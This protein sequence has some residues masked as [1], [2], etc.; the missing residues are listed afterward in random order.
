MRRLLLLGCA[1]ASLGLSAGSAA[2]QAGAA[3]AVYLDPSKPISQRVDDLIGRM[4]L[5]EKAVQM[6]NSTPAIPR[7]GVPAYDYWSEALHGVMLNARSS[8]VFPEPIGLAASFDAPQIKQMASAI[9]EEGRAYF[10]IV[11]RHG[12]HHF[13]QG[14]TFFA[15][16]INI[17]RDPRWGRGQE[18]YG[19]DPWLTGK[20]GVAFITGLQG[21]DPVHLRAGATAKHIAAYSGPEPGRYEFD[22]KVSQHDL[23]DTFLPPFRAAVVE[24]KVQSVMC[25]YLMVNGVPSCANAYLLTETLRK[26][27]DF[28]GFVISDCGAVAN[29][30]AS[31]RVAK[32]EVDAR[33]AAVRAGVDNECTQMP[34][35]V[36]GST[37]EVRAFEDAVRQ[38]KLSEADLDT[39][40]K[41][42]FAVRFALGL[43]DPPDQV[44]A[45]QVPD[46]ALE[47][48]EN[49]ALALAMARKSMVLLKNSGVLPL[50]SSVRKIAV[51]GTLADQKRVLD[52]NYSSVPA[53]PVTA[54]A[55]IRDQFKGAEIV[56]EPGTNFNVAPSSVPSDVL[57]TE[58]GEAGLKAEFFDNDA[59]TGTPIDARI[60]PQISSTGSRKAPNAAIRWTGWLVPKESGSYKL[61]L[62]GRSNILYLDGK[63]LVD[64]RG[65]HVIY[66]DT[67]DVDLVAGHRYAITVVSP[68]TPV[69][70]VELV[71]S[72]NAS[73]DQLD[74]RI[75]AAAADA[76]V[77][78]AVVGI[79]S[80]LEGEEMGRDN[81]GFR[82]GDRTSLDLPKEEEDLLKAIKATGKPLVVVLMNGSAM[83][84]NWADQHADAILEAWY[85]GQEGGT[86]VAQTLAGAN[87]PAGRLP[88][89]FY[90]GVDQLP[91]IEDYSMAKRTYRYFTGAPLYP[92]GY[93]LSYSTFA[94]SGLKL[95]TKAIKAGEPLTVSAQVK[96]TSA[97][98][99]D[100]V[101]QLYLTFPK[102]SG[103]PVR[104]L[105]GFTRVHLAPGESRRVTF[106]LTARDLSYVNEAGEHL[107]GAG[108]YGISVGGGQ[109]TTAAPKVEAALKI[110]GEKQLE[111]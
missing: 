7:L 94:Y 111:R 106:T 64:A 72:R 60:D 33:A 109:P 3:S 56:Y 36:T 96:N 6:I 41:R 20:L 79:T 47:S 110:T 81:P 85:P 26:S 108:A 77:A 59:L 71:W 78:I 57:R 97:T 105:R 65:M 87:N 19:E 95:S 42:T 28:K 82:G 32:S 18:T 54:L 74:A 63:P 22:A 45:A 4:T 83:A 69:H 55:G 37:V 66:T 102:L 38:G 48:D 25:D 76:D 99:G 5:E 31:Q 70:S 89:T 35:A 14:L 104:A 17:F 84:V 91:P 88:V 34:V 49:R 46:S 98:A 29:I 107:V 62:R 80:E 13:K 43:F 75:A 1:A 24:G 40:L 68:Q 9:G 12:E 67:R 93:G 16:N 50:K 23:E 61:G 15:P 52:G 53:R 58:D 100:E 103:A 44:K 90:K 8:T 51:F 92:F 73:A 10:N 27:W 101:A 21:D 2:A 11:G 86:A 30:Y 39:A